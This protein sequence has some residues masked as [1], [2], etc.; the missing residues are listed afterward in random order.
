MM[1]SSWGLD[2]AFLFYAV[3]CGIAIWVC[4]SKFLETRGKSLEE[5]ELDLHKAA[6]EDITADA[7]K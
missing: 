5:I 2:N 4:H 3:I 1:L 7:S 6:G